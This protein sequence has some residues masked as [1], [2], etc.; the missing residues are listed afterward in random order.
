MNAPLSKSFQLA[1]LTLLLFL[2]SCYKA[3]FYQNTNVV[4]GVQHEEWT[5]FFLYGLVGSETYNVQQF[6]GNTEVA[7]IR[8]GGNFATGLLSTITIGIYTPRKVYVT[9]ASFSGIRSE[10]PHRKL[11]VA[12]NAQGEPVYA[13]VSENGH[14]TIARVSPEREG[15]YRMSHERE[16]SR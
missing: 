4:R 5:S 12:L 11:E 1:P 13:E 7:E 8:T 9:C 6:C 10:A 3:T 14:T 15:V 2:A 16:V